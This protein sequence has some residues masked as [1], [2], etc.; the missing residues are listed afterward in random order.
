MLNLLFLL[1]FIHQ[2]SWSDYKGLPDSIAVS[3]GTIARTFYEW[4]F[5]KTEEDGKMYFEV[6][7]RFVPEKSWTTTN[8]Q[9]TL[10]HENTHYLISEMWAE[11]CRKRLAKYQGI[12]TGQ[13]N[14]AQKIYDYCWK[15]ND[16]LQNLFDK[17]TKNSRVWLI[18]KEWEEN[19]L[20]A[21]NEKS[22]PN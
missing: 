8:S 13:A 19:I 2:L 3:H 6:K 7:S 16:N 5:I 18:E 1:P 20:R 12:A 21:M 4:E 9:Y 11:R 17:E 14:K 10:S 15:E 22:D